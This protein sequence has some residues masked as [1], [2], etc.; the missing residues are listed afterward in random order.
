MHPIARR[1]AQTALLAGLAATVAGCATQQDIVQNKEDLL[2]AAGF[3]ARPADSPERL[4]M[5]QHLPADRFVMRDRNGETVYLYGDPVVCDCVYFGSSVAYSK[6]RQE[7][8]QQ[9]IANQ[10]QEIADEQQLNAD[11]FGWGGWGWGPWGAGFGGPG[12]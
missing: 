2:A 5:L 7:R 6:Y 3:V 9:D 12:F 10:Q 4:A 1:L 8:F 11:Q